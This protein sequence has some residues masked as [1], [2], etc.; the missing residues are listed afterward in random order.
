MAYI[1]YSRSVT[2]QIQPVEGAGTH[3]VA[4]FIMELEMLGILRR[5]G[6]SPNVQFNR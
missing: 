5:S 1:I 4:H 3:A 6:W 2:K